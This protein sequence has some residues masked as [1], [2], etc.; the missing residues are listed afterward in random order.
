MR[1]LSLRLGALFALGILAPAAF[2]YAGTSFYW[3]FDDSHLPLALHGTAIPAATPGPLQLAIYV[4]DQLLR[5]GFFDALEVF[6]VPVAAFTNNPKA[7]Y[8]SFGVLAF[9][10]YA[11]AFVIFGLSYVL[12]L[13]RVANT[14]RVKPPPP[15][16]SFSSP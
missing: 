14:A 12:R 15:I 9:H 2:L 6:Q 11:E 3:W 16:L 13:S 1:E 10:L 5:G 4:A 7:Y 8:Y